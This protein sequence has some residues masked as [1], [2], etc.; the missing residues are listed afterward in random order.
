MAINLVLV[1]TVSG[2]LGLALR[3]VLPRRDRHGLAMMP[4]LGI[5][6]GSLGWAVS[7]WIGVDPQGLWGWVIS[8]GL[9]LVVTV[10]MGLAVPP[11]RD[12]ADAVL[13]AKLTKA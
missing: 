11:R 4:A 5:I 2:L 8:L 9:V 1:I 3:Y 10:A 6:A 13:W 7:M 12:A